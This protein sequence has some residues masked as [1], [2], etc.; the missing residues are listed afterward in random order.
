MLC[1]VNMSERLDTLGCASFPLYRP[2]NNNDIYPRRFFVVYS[3]NWRGRFYI[4]ASEPEDM[5]RTRFLLSISSFH[6]NRQVWLFALL[7]CLPPAGSRRF[8]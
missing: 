3:S 1:H 7:A 4:S 2:N 5:R 8:L 6:I